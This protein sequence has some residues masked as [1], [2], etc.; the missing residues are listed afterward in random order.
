MP[1]ESVPRGL[2]AEEYA[3]LQAKQRQLD[4][5]RPYQRRA[6]DVSHVLAHPKAE[7]DSGASLPAALRRPFWMWLRVKHKIESEVCAKVWET[8]AAMQED[9][10]KHGKAW[11]SLETLC[12]EARAGR[13]A[14]RAARRWLLENGWLVYV[15]ACKGGRGRSRIVD[16][17]PGWYRVEELWQAYRRERAMQR[18]MCK[19][20]QKPLAGL[21]RAVDRQ[22]AKG[23]AYRP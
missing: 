5:Q 11:P 3:E 18:M 21:I 13:K 2:T 19:K 15:G 9:A 6:P 10:S 12:R 23:G 20:G 16:P 8:Y 17:S 1:S 14:V 7:G 4:Q 22:G